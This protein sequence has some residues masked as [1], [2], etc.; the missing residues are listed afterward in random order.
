MLF[1]H[2]VAVQDVLGLVVDQ[3]VDPLLPVVADG[4]GI[5]RDVGVVADV[6]VVDQVGDRVLDLAQVVRTDVE[7]AQ[8]RVLVEPRGPFAQAALTLGIALAADGV[9]GQPGAVERPERELVERVVRN[10]QPVKVGQLLGREILGQGLQFVVGQVE[11]Y[12]CRRVLAAEAALGD[13]VDAATAQ[14]DLGNFVSPGFAA[15]ESV[16]TRRPLYLPSSSPSK[17]S[18]SL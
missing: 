11:R 3:V 15:R 2:F 7:P 14:D 5:E 16:S 17:P 12:E 10:I 18:I 6:E 9:D 13:F 4:R 8:A 1:E